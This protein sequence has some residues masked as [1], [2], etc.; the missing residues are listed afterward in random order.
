MNPSSFSSGASFRVG[1][2]P[3]NATIGPVFPSP[4]IPAPTPPAPLRP[5]QLDTNTGLNF[6][7][8]VS[9]PVSVFVNAGPSG[10]FAGFTGRF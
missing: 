3:V 1:P 4:A 9:R 5:V 6:T 7:V 10:G 2:L 8:P